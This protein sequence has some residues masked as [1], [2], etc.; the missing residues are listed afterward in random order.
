MPTWDEVAEALEPTPLNPFKYILDYLERIAKHGDRDVILYAS[1]FEQKQG[2]V[3]EMSVESQDMQGYMTCCKGLKKRKLDLILHTPGGNGLAALDHIEYLR[4][5]FDHIRAI[6]PASAYSAGT[7]LACGCDEIVMG[8]YSVLGPTDPQILIDRAYVPA[9]AIQE[10]FNKAKEEIVAK[11]V[12]AEFWLNRL[13]S[14]PFGKLSQIDQ[15]VNE[16]VADLKTL[17]LGRMFQTSPSDNV[18]ENKNRDKTVDEIARKLGNNKDEKQHGKGISLAKAR[19]FGLK[20][21]DLQDDKV[22]E[23]LVLT[24]YHAFTR[25]CQTKPVFKVI[26]SSSGKSLLKVGSR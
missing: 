19:S 20:V 1:A 23:D 8:P 17:L 15:L 11:P 22:L 16:S 21:Q 25:T 7:I 12:L 4:S 2:N 13:K 10:E 18:A 9:F 26:M 24:V 14:V 5:R 3:H 6:I